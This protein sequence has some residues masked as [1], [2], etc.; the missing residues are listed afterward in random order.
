MIDRPHPAAASGESMVDLAAQLLAGAP[1]HARQVIATHRER[2]DGRC[3]ECG[4][5]MRWPCFLAVA[6]RRAV[7]LSS[8]R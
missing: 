4:P 1:T 7:Q 5:L 6:A 2:P 3:A 8:P